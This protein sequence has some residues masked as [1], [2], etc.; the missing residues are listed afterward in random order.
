MSISNGC[1]LYTATQTHL[2]GM[3]GKYSLVALRPQKQSGIVC[4]RT[5]FLFQIACLSACRPSLVLRLSALRVLWL[6]LIH[7]SLVL[8]LSALHVLL[9]L[10]SLVPSLRP[11]L[12]RDLLSATAAAASCL[13][14]VLHIR[15]VFD[16]L[17]ELT[18][19]AADIVVG[20]QAEGND[21]NETDPNLRVSIATAKNGS[22]Q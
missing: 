5:P 9:L 7:S 6:L 2:R 10:M 11:S 12:H 21:G 14:H 17:V 18:D 13:H 22:V 4:P 20:L 19:V 1:H 3:P 8:R 15:P 16:I